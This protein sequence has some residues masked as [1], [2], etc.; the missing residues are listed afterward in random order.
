MHARRSPE[1][2]LSVSTLLLAVILVLFAG[3]GTTPVG[4][5][6]AARE[7]P[8]LAAG[9]FPP[10]TTPV[11][12]DSANNS[13]FDAAQYA[14]LP[15]EG[16]IVIQGTIGSRDD[17]DVY[18]LGPALA[19]DRIT[20]DVTGYDGLNTVAALFDG[21][22]E[23]LDGNDDRSYYM[24]QVNPYFAYTLRADSPNLFVTIAVT[25]ATHF[26]NNAGRYDFGSYN[27]RISRQPNLAVP[28]ARPQIVYLDYAGGASVRIAGEPVEI[29]R[30]FSAE[31]I[32]A[33]MAGQTP[34]IRSL[35]LY[36][37][38]KDLA[39]YNVVLVDGST[40]PP[41]SVPHSKLYF[42]NFNASYLGLA[43]NVDT[44]NSALEQ[45]AIIY[46]ED[47]SMY[48][49]LR[50]TAEE[51]GQALANIAS[52]ELGHLL[53]LEHTAE[54]GDLMATAASARQVLEVDALFKRSRLQLAVF[55]IGWQN[56]PNLLMQNVGANPLANVS[57]RSLSADAPSSSSV[58]RDEL[59]MQD[60]PI[61]QCGGCK[62]SHDEDAH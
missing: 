27:I 45:K 55:P 42:G 58:I 47:L 8:D 46:A 62:H 40:Q 26:A 38:Q 41:P 36:H 13:A 59:G 5:T 32:S 33:R 11:V 15:V 23:L 1:E 37:M 39:D 25:R 50:A 7:R 22:Q 48:E 17:V 61:L 57:A 34:Y 18:A 10:V 44:G 2:S 53:G 4:T 60:I 51:L 21:G 12:E 43:D 30:P 49:S 16:E 54:S 14:T 52:H 35:I 31:A 56:G 19:G 28:S 29:M 6:G 24:S 9:E 20:V 3:C